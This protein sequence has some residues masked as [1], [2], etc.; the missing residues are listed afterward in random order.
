MEYE[1]SL[2]KNL[3][4]TFT[5]TSLPLCSA[6]QLFIHSFSPGHRLLL[7][8]ACCDWRDEEQSARVHVWRDHLLPHRRSW[9]NIG[10]WF[11]RFSCFFFI[12]WGR[13]LKVLPINIAFNRCAFP[14]RCI[15]SA[16]LGVVAVCVV[17][18]GWQLSNLRRY[19]SNELISPA[20]MC[21][22]LVTSNDE[23][24]YVH[25]LGNFSSSGRN[26]CSGPCLSF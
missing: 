22:S 17:L 26:T 3:N 12:F 23:H 9:R 14:H 20:L 25:P 6:G 13:T 18:F 16:F 1:K 11:G 10:G 7:A 19:S 5:N 2:L 21:T 24:L 8:L 4:N 15:S